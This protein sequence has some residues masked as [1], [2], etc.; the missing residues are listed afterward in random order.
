VPVLGGSMS[1]LESRRSETEVSYPEFAEGMIAAGAIP[2]IDGIA[3]HA[4]ASPRFTRD[5]SPFLADS[6]EGLREVLK[7]HGIKGVPI[8]LTEF[9]VSTTGSDAV[10]EAGQAE[11][12]ARTARW[13]LA[14]PDLGAFIVHA[15]TEPLY[16]E[17]GAHEVG[18]G[19]TR[20][21]GNGGLVEKPAFRAL[22]E[23]VHRRS[24]ARHLRPGRL[25]LSVRARGSVRRGGP[26]ATVLC[27][28]PC[29]VRAT[30]L[31]GKHPLRVR[32]RARERP[33]A[34]REFTVWLAR[35]AARSVGGQRLVL[36]VRA[37]LD[38]RSQS[39][40]LVLG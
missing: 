4:N 17:G 35:S 19:I 18:F 40:R 1:P 38:A 34:V 29:R 30:L 20:L 12:L 9:G 25:I 5:G 10:S 2:V 28:S 39:R 33:G 26:V 3:I 23:I 14:Q 13:A 8:W 36:R 7:R 37:R 24:Y 22:R 11:R 32:L 31:D 16:Y 15:L 21:D 27:E 6:V